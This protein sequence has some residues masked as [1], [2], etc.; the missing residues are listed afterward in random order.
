MSY[1]P[2]RVLSCLQPKLQTLSL[3]VLKTAITVCQTPKK[4]LECGSISFEIYY[5]QVVT[6]IGFEKL[7]KSNKTSAKVDG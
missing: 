4:N 5:N 3:S 6:E 7:S 2:K 1:N